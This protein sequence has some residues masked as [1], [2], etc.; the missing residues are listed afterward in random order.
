MNL[1]LTGN[2]LTIDD[3]ARVARNQ[4]AVVSMDQHAMAVVARS[5]QRMLQ[6]LASGE[7]VYGLTTGLGSRVTETLSTAEAA[8]FSLDTL[9]GRAHATGNPLPVDFDIIAPRSSWTVPLISTW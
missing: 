9:R 8:Q 1:I 6:A 7:R 4:A 2:T 5:R 3:L